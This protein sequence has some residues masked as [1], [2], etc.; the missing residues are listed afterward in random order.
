MQREKRKLGNDSNF[1]ICPS[2][3]VRE[4]ANELQEGLIIKT[5]KNGR[6]AKGNNDNTGEHTTDEDF[7]QED[8]GEESWYI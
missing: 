6:R 2:C 8:Y 4:Q 5:S 3:G 1:F 7:Y